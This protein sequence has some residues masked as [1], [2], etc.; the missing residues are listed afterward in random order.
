M[1]MQTRLKQFRKRLPRFRS[2]RRVGVN[3]AAVVRT[4]GV[5]ALMHGYAGLG[6]SPTMLMHQRRAVMAAAAPKNGLGGQ[7]MEV[8]LMLADGSKKGRA[9]PAFHAHIDVVQHWAQAIWNGWLPEAS[10]T[11]SL[12]YA[13][14]RVTGSARP[15][16]LVTGPAAALLCTLDRVGWTVDSASCLVTDTG[17]TLH[18][19]I[20]PPII[21][22]RCMEAAVRR[23][24]WRNLGS[25][26]PP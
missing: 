14:G 24:R 5:A 18:L 20:D 21:V 19:H 11:T 23:W 2:L 16:S 22:A 25:C 17:R 4:G 1:V 3:T 10:L 13:R 12:N 7:Q 9:D 15:W 8:A 26:T 6:V